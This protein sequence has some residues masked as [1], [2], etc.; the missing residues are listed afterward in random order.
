MSPYGHP[1]MQPYPGYMMHG[2]QGYPQMPWGYP[3]PPSTHSSPPPQDEKKDEGQ[4]AILD[5]IKKQEEARIAWQKEMI[6][7]KEAEAA[8]KAAAKAKEE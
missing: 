2:M 5:L 4:A 3:P 1:G 7:A 8:E 6:A